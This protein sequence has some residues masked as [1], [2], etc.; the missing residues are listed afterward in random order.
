MAN[1]HQGGAEH[2]YMAYGRQRVHQKADLPQFSE[3]GP[4][5]PP[6]SLDGPS[7]TCKAHAPQTTCVANAQANPCS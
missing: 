2:A 7:P 5:G 1:D 3:S 4:H 6:A